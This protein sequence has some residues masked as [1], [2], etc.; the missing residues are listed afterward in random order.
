MDKKKFSN[1]QKKKNF[2]TDVKL[3]FIVGLLPIIF[4]SSI[5][6]KART[7]VFGDGGGAGYGYFLIFTT[8]LIILCCLIFL[9]IFSLFRKSVKSVISGV[10]SFF[11]AGLI[12]FSILYICE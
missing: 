4:M 3:G 9:V 11:L 7:I 5:F 6:I 10:I 1:N 2:N 8:P 12:L